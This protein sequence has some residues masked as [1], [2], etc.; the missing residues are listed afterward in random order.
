VTTPQEGYAARDFVASHPHT[1]GMVFVSRKGKF[2]LEC[3]FGHFTPFAFKPGEIL[4]DAIKRLPACAECT[5][6]VMP[7]A[8]GE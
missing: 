8:A 1:S 4:R 6:S 5:R 3:A 7:E 2:G